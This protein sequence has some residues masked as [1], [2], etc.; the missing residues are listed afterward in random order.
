M[1]SLKSWQFS[2]LNLLA[3]LVLVLVA[4][5]ITLFLGNRTVQAQAF[6]RQRTINQGLRLSRLNTQLIRA[7]ATM[8][9]QRDDQ[10][11][12]DLLAA[13]GITFTVNPPAAQ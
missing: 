9:A 2:L 7:L 4:I 13:H 12:R 11:L 8:S 6:E 1:K 5:N 10:Q 3:G